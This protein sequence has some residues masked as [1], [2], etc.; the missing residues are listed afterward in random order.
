MPSAMEQPKLLPFPGAGW[1]L[2]AHTTA[3]IVP[4]DELLRVLR[5]RT[6]SS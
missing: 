5:R 1:A 4:P 2:L 3:T 6:R